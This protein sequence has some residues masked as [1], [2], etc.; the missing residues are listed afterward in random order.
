MALISL[1]KPTRFWR[2][3]PRRS[4]LH[5]ITISIS[6]RVIMVISVLKAG[7]LVATFAARY[8]FICQR[9]D[10]DPA[11]TVGNSFEFETLVLDRLAVSRDTK[12]NGDAFGHGVIIPVR[13]TVFSSF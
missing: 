10:D 3:R 1:R 13:E 6:R 7:T 9:R 11:Q 2:D 8:A 5:A 4:T 12:V